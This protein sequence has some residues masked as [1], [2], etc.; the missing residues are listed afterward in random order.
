M[1][2]AATTTFA[3]LTRLTVINLPPLLPEEDAEQAEAEE[4]K[5]A[6]PVWKM[7]ET[8]FTEQKDVQLPLN[9]T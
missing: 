6:R 1:S 3:S 7:S 9:L 5:G 4:K 8:V 2:T